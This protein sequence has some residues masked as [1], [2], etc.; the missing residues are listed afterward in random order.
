MEPT[1]F[2]ERFQT[3]CA[4]RGKAPNAVGREL[5]LSSATTSQWKRRGSVPSARILAMLADYFGVSSDELI[6]AAP[7]SPAPADRA[8]KEDPDD[9][10]DFS[11]G[12]LLPPAAGTAPRGSRVTRGMG[13]KIGVLSSVG[14]GIP[15]EAVDVFD[16]DD[17]EAWEEI[18]ADLAKGGEFFALRIKG[19]SML[20][21]IRRGDVVIVRKQDTVEEG[22]CAIVLVN[23]NEGVC[24][25]IHY[26]DDG[27]SLLSNNEE[28]PPITFTRQQITDMPVRI[29]GKVEEIRGKP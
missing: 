20:P 3:L 18:T 7:L 19:D 17:P 2:W 11:P 4:R 28:Y 24:K 23:G 22:D 25:R 13:R 6:G 5:G 10:A 16:Q 14:A 8:E 21:R 29:V 26:R 27:I 9:P 1:L 12:S 15:I